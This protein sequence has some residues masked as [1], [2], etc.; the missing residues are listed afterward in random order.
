VYLALAINWL[1]SPTAARLKFP[2]TARLLKAG[3]TLTTGGVGFW[4]W[5]DGFEGPLGESFPEQDRSS[6]QTAIDMASAKDLVIN[7]RPL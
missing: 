5:G 4:G 3:G 6:G 2:S 7:I 1:V